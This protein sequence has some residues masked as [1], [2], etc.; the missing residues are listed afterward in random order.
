MET[1]VVLA[2]PHRIFRE[3]LRGMLGAHE[4]LAVIGE[5]RDGTQAVE[6]AR[7]RRPHIVL[8]DLWLPRLSAVDATIRICER[9]PHSRV[10]ILSSH[11]PDDRVDD[12]VRAGASGYLSCDSDPSEI[13]AAVEA[14]ERGQAYISPS[15]TEHL[16]AAVARPGVDGAARPLQI[17]S[18]REREVLQLVAEGLSNKEIAAHLGLSARTIESHRANLLAKLGARGTADLV[19]VAIRAQ[20]VAA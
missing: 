1:R 17:L 2:Y 7:E 5:A 15:V 8:M 16:I 10:L 14:L 13:F 6:L 19:R 18:S 3:A 20:L 11:G 9:A 4:K 12:I